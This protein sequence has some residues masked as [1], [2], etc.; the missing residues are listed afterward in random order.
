LQVLIDTNILINIIKSDIVLIDK[1]QTLAKDYTIYVNPTIV[2]EIYQGARDKE[3]SIIKTFL[4]YTQ[5]LNLDCETGKLAGE[6]AKQ[7]SK[8]HHTITLDDYIIAASAKQHKCKL[9]TLNKK[10]FPMFSGVELV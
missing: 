3:I 8:S 10:H 1:F 2:A 7:Y 5:C 4:Q 6:L 9:W